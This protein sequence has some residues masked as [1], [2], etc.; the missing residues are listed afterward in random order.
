VLLSSVLQYLPDPYAILDELV[1]IGP[2]LIII[3]LTI[4]NSKKFD[5]IFIQNVPKSIYEAS[6]TVRSL[7][8]EKL[9]SSI[10]IF[11]YNIIADFKTLNFPQLKKLESQFKG[12]IFSKK[13]E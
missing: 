9:I 11:G 6:Y 10:D 12:F 5:V 7:S 13:Y 3:D 1:G 4:V 8:E 2:D